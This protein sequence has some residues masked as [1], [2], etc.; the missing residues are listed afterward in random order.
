MKW[1]CLSTVIFLLSGCGKTNVP[2]EA[3]VQSYKAYLDKIGNIHS[4]PAKFLVIDYGHKIGSV[5][6][7]GTVSCSDGVIRSTWT[8][9]RDGKKVTEDNKISEAD[10][11]ALWKALEGFEKFIPAG[12]D[13][14]TDPINTHVIGTFAHA[15]GRNDSQRVFIVPN[16]EEKSAQFGSWLKTLNGP[17][18]W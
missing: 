5:M 7:H 12:L 16:A 15:E 13:V 9:E 18:V 10:F 3:E 11:S 4:L 17:W 2:K 14:K 1:V 6:Y 8:Y